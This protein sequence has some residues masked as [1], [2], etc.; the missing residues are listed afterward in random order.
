[1][2]LDPLFYSK[3]NWADA[4]TKQLMRIGEI[5]FNHDSFFDAQIL[6]ALAAD[7]WDEEFNN[8]IAEIDA[9]W[10]DDMK[11]NDP[12]L[13]SRAGKQKTIA[14]IEAI[15]RLLARNGFLLSKSGFTTSAGD[16]ISGGKDEKPMKAYSGPMPAK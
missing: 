13:M 11:S 2:S 14:Y 12:I 6:K 16:H 10:D 1:M 7:K 9:Q 3:V 5:E 8:N 4:M 15:M